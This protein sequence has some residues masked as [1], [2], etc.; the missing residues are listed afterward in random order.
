M[1]TQTERIMFS[2]L[3][4]LARSDL[5][6][7]KGNKKTCSLRSVSYHNFTG[8]RTVSSLPSG[9]SKHIKQLFDLVRNKFLNLEKELP[10]VDVFMLKVLCH[11]I[12]SSE[13]K[14]CECFLG[15]FSHFVVQKRVILI[16]RKKIDFSI[17]RPGSAWRPKNWF[18][19]YIE[20]NNFRLRFSRTT[21]AD[22]IILNCAFLA[23]I[24]IKQQYHKNLTQITCAVCLERAYRQP[25]IIKC[26]K[27]SQTPLTR[28]VGSHTYNMLHV[29]VHQPSQ[30]TVFVVFFLLSV[31]LLLF[32]W[33][34][35]DVNSLYRYLILC[36][37]DTFQN[38]ALACFVHTPEYPENNWKT[39][40]NV[41][42]D[43]NTTHSQCGEFENTEKTPSE[44]I[45]CAKMNSRSARCASVRVCVCVSGFDEWF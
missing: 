17:F 7:V 38:T 39:Q 33:R 24:Y 10:V 36:A 6:G 15:N 29:R 8:P 31:A 30:V 27:A 18:R 16:K 28:H 21:F 14:H 43:E 23:S 26:V 3:S 2:F 34:S 40:I 19:I 5:R 45:W 13:S 12:I 41:S 35:I 20:N 25:V 11:F 9:K 1:E 37:R 44:T 42:R 32:C 22:C 4:F